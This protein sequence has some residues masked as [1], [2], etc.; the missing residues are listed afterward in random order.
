MVRFFEQISSIMYSILNI[1]INVDVEL[2]KSNYFKNRFLL[3]RIA[4][5]SGLAVDCFLDVG[6][7]VLDADYFGAIITT[8]RQN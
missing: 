1:N 8:K 2:T 7:G 6:A 4:P 3:G 5:R